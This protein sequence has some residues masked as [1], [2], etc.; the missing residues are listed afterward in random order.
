MADATP[1]TPVSDSIVS[2]DV[3]TFQVNMQNN[4][5]SYSLLLTWSTGRVDRRERIIKGADFNAMVAAVFQAAPKR[6]FLTW[7]QSNNY[8]TNLTIG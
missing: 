6:K 5:A 4:T 1:T 3:E 2:I 8:E 7:L